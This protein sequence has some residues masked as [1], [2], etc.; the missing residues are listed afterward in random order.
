MRRNKNEKSLPILG[1]LFQNLN[2]NLN[3]YLSWWIAN[4]GV[5]PLFLFAAF[6]FCPIFELRFDLL[7]F[8]TRVFDT[9]L[10]LLYIRNYNCFIIF[11]EEFVLRIQQS[12]KVF[13]ILPLLSGPMMASEV[14]TNRNQEDKKVHTIDIKTGEVEYF[15]VERLNKYHL[16]NKTVASFRY[17]KASSQVFVKGK[18]PGSSQILIW[19][20]QDK[21][22]KKILINVLPKKT[23]LKLLNLSLEISTLGVKTIAHSKYI[24]VTGELSSLFQYQRLNKLKRK[25]SQEIELNVQ[26]NKDL[27]NQIVA[28]VYKQFF[29][30]YIEN[31][32]CYTSQIQVLCHYPLDQ[33]LP[34]TMV[35]N[36][37]SSFDIVFIPTTRPSEQ[38][39]FKVK[40]KLIQ[41]EKLDGEELNWGLDK[42]QTQWQGVFDNGL[43]SLISSNEIFLNQNNLIIS[44]LA[45]PIAQITTSSPLKLQVGS[46]IPFTTKGDGLYS[47]S[48]SWKFAGLKISLKLSEVKGKWVLDYH[49]EFTRPEGQGKA[50]SGNKEK[51]RT[52]ITL[53][54]TS[55]LFQI[56]FK[57][58]GKSTSQMPWLS[59]VPILGNLFQSKSMQSNY[60]K[61]TGLIVI[62]KQ[63][64]I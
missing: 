32:K 9:I 21:A 56:G 16:A 27:K 64:D 18:S 25:Y 30:Q 29:L 42:I 37:K 57:T 31:I 10:M 40:L 47:S 33:K 46:D 59:Q 63:K 24:E 38:V 48:T 35:E 6:L 61:V 17:D 43:N 41:V 45:E 62:T 36:L 60:K 3:S 20:N 28:L 8:V 51:G 44:T 26:L 50:I 23:S 1:G 2:F 19:S 58:S 15:K 54:E 4:L 53:G 5:V 34:P 12:V 11:K 13:F 14:V 49:T 55:S 52:Y 7:F 39:V 22:P